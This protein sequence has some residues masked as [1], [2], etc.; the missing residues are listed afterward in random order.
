MTTIVKNKNKK[1]QQVESQ[2][3]L[4]TV[5]KLDINKVVSDVSSLQLSIQNT[6]ANLSAELANKLQQIENVDVAISL[7]EQR[8]QE[9]FDIEKE[10]MTIEEIKFTREQQQKENEKLRKEQEENWKQQEQ[11]RNK[12]WMREKEEYDYKKTI[13]RKK[14]ED[15]FNNQMFNAKRNEELRKATLENSWK[16]REQLLSSKENEFIILQNKVAEFD[17]I[18]NQTKISVKE[19]VTAELNKEYEYKINL[20]KK[21]CDGEIKLK[22]QEINSQQY[23]ILSMKKQIESLELQLKSARDDAKEVATQALQSAAGRQVVE[24][25]QKTVSDRESNSKNK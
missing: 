24:A 5:Q 9:L 23:T 7:K 15:E 10:Q 4:S 16:E 8:L 22:E 14:A 21:E 18:L 25:L 17:N 2:S 11:E 6:L 1:S 12:T 20:A 19:Q 3:I 13:E